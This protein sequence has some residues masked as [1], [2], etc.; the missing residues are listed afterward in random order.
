MAVPVV[1][2][3]VTAACGGSPASEPAAGPGGGGEVV[4]ARLVSFEPAGHAPETL[5]AISDAPVDVGAFQGWFAAGSAATDAVKARP[6]ERYV[7]VT[8]VTGCT[9]PTRAELVRTGDDL[10][11]RFSGGDKPAEAGCTGEIGPV[12]QFAVAPGLLRGVRTIGG[13]APLSPAGPGR[14]DAFVELGPAAALDDVPPAEL[15]T[16][17]AA[18]LSHVLEG[19]AS[20]NLDR[21]RT[22][23]DARPAADRRGFTFVLGGCAEDGA[24]LIVQQRSLTAKL[25]GNTNARCIAAAHFLVTFSIP[26]DRVPPGAVPSS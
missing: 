20:T 15:D 19:A 7:V 12:A 25:T 2:A 4:P 1:V 17:G 21:A 18:E 10:T 22:A 23:L 13:R 5:G 26:R 16:D 3:A 6:G 9:T 14:L 8:G 24:V 11:A